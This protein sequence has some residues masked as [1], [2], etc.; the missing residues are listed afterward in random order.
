MR[1]PCPSRGFLAADPEVGAED[2]SRVLDRIHVNDIWSR[3]PFPRPKN[4][5]RNFRCCERGRNLHSRHP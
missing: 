2:L 1:N 4:M 5:L 3:G